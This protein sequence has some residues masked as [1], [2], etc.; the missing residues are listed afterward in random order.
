MSFTS[1]SSFFIPAQHHGYPDM[2]N[3]LVILLASIAIKF[4]KL[5]QKKFLKSY[6]EEIAC[7]F[8]SKLNFILVRRVGSHILLASFP[9]PHYVPISK[10][11][12]EHCSLF[13]VE[14]GLLATLTFSL[15]YGHT[16]YP[17]PESIQLFSL[18]LSSKP[19][20]CTCFSASRFLQINAHCPMN[21]RGSP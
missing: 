8:H 17:M 4:P 9:S 6:V 13:P 20:S 18:S 10:N 12:E 5:K 15:G 19:H 14:R 7:T 1:S 16:G 3:I 21:A 2:P 11:P